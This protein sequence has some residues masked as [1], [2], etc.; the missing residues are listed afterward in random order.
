MVIFANFLPTIQVLKKQL[1]VK[2]TVNMK[3]NVH[4]QT[5]GYVLVYNKY[6]FSDILIAL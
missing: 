6:K 1:P 3:T 5:N 4:I 2:H